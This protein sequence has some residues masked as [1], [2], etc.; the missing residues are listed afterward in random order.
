MKTAVLIVAATLLSGPALRSQDLSLVEPGDILVL[1]FVPPTTLDGPS[2]TKVVQVTSEGKIVLPS[3]DG[4]KLP[5]LEVQG[6]SLS[7][8]YELVLETTPRRWSRPKI[9]VYLN[10]PPRVTVERGTAAQLLGQ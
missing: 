10:Y 8:V 1:K 2:V 3:V 9:A 4:V 7:E 6:L 5:D